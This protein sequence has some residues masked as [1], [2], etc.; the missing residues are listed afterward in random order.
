MNSYRQIHFRLGRIARGV[1]VSFALCLT[2]NAHASERA[3]SSH[4]VALELQ[5]DSRER[6]V[7]A[8]IA[9]PSRRLLA[10]RSYLRAGTNLGQRWSW[11][12]GQIRRYEQST[13][14]QKLL[15]DL[16]VVRH[17]FERDN[18]GFTLYANTQVRSLDT[19]IERWNSNPRVGKTAGNLHELA[20]KQVDRAE[21]DAQSLERLKELL[22][23]WRPAP[24]APL[25]APGLS[26][27]GQMRAIDFQIMRGKRIVAATE[28]GAVQRDWAAPGWDRKL[29]RAIDKAG[30][31][32]AGPLQSPNE[33]W[34]YEYI[35]EAGRAAAK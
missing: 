7:L 27:H 20:A 9:D 19:Q 5:L 6:A 30:G 8:Q 21:P 3:L 12:D 24:V 22:L 34:H 2:A 4:M 23:G 26:K 11:T 25:A 31:R 10:L 16:D 28:V 29:R 1:L 13:E 33:P 17:A 18:P 32:F 35:G 15:A 14:Y